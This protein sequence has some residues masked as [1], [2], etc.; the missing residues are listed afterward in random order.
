[1]EILSLFLAAGSSK[2]NKWLQMVNLNAI[3]FSK[4]K[5]GKSTMKGRKMNTVSARKEDR[6]P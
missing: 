6:P 2:E 3:T 1:M 4:A 5:N